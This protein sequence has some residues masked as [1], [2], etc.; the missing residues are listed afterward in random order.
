MKLTFR[1]KYW[2]KFCIEKK[3]KVPCHDGMAYP[4]DGEGGLLIWNVAVNILNKLSQTANKRWSSSMGVGR[5][6]NK[7]STIKKISML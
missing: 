7:S 4:Q 2:I 6:A 3:K 1:D 5:G